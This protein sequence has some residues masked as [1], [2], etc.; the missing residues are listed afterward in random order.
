MMLSLEK[1]SGVKGELKCEPHT[2]TEH[3]LWRR[4]KN[5]VIQIRK[6]FANP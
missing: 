2:V 5:L 1:I 6:I 4:R 3:L